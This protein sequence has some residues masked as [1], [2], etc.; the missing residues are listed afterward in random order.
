[1]GKHAFETSITDGAH[2]RLAGM[3]GD[4]AGTTRVWFGPDQLADESPQSGRIRVV[5]GGRFLLHEYDSAFQGEAQ[6][7][8]AIY[9][10]HLDAGTCESAWADSFHTGTSIMFSSA[11][12]DGDRFAVLGGY[13][14]GKGGPR[15]GWRTEI[16]QP[17]DDELVITMFN[18]SPQGEETKAVETRY[19]RVQS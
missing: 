11:A 10:V 16:E 14:D 7:G 12:T 9:A 18:I 2:K 8:A 19:V 5:A 17:G 3:T 13:D 6:Q 1:M 15:W 4:W